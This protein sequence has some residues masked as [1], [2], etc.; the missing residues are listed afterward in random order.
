MQAGA[1]SVFGGSF[2]YSKR[3]RLARPKTGEGAPI[4]RGAKAV[5]VDSVAKGG[6]KTC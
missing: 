3:K 1:K 4:L 2:P 6:Q 5:S